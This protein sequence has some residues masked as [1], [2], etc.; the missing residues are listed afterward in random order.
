MLIAS[1]A[2]QIA[3]ITKPAFE[4]RCMNQMHLRP[5]VTLK[6]ISATEVEVLPNHESLQEDPTEPMDP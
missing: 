4:T 3:M 5:W 6:R 2:A 1:D